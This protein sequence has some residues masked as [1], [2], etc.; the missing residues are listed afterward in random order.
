M[1]HSFFLI[2]L[3]W[4]KHHAKIKEKDFRVLIKYWS[5]WLFLYLILYIMNHMKAIT[6]FVLILSL[7]I[8]NTFLFYFAS[9]ES[10]DNEALFILLYIFSFYFHLL[11]FYKHGF[12]LCL[13]NERIFSR[14]KTKNLL[15]SSFFIVLVS[16]F[17]PN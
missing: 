3:D 15:C 16:S 1:W 11:S 2:P 4:S 7:F 5:K 17:N 6:R 8:Q 14:K 12:F 9:W 13:P 10:H